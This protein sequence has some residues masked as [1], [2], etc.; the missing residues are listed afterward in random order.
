[1]FKGPLG[2]RIYGKGGMS[3]DVLSKLYEDEP[4][5]MFEEVPYIKLDN[6]QELIG[7]YGYYQAHY[8]SHLGFLVKEP[9]SDS[10]L[11]PPPPP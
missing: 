7:V 8:I 3:K 5:M 1:M 11:P 2:F 6:D 4:D 10:Q 9:V